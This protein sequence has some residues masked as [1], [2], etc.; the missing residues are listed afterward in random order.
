[1]NAH[2]L[3][4]ILVLVTLLLLQVGCAI[5]PQDSEPR[6]GPAGETVNI[7]EMVSID[8]REVEG[9]LHTVFRFSETMNNPPTSGRVNFP[10]GFFDGFADGGIKSG[11]QLVG[12]LSFNQQTGLPVQLVDNTHATI[13]A[14]PPVNFEVQG[15]SLLLTTSSV[16]PVAPGS[17]ALS[18]LPGVFNLNPGGYNLEMVATWPDAST[19]TFHKLLLVSAALVPHLG[20][21]SFGDSYVG[22]TLILSNPGPSD[23]TVTVRFLRPDGTLLVV[24]IDDL[25]GSIFNLEVP[26]RE[27][28]I[29]DVESADEGTIETG[30]ARL[31]GT[32][33]FQASVFFPT[34]SDS[35]EGGVLRTAAG[36]AAAPPATLHVVPA[37]IVPSYGINTA[38]AIA[39]PTSATANVKLILQ[40]TP[41]VERE[42]QMPSNTQMAAF[43]DSFFDVEVA[44]ELVTSM[45]IYSDTDL[46]AMA[47]VTLNGEQIASLP[48]GTTF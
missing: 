42:I 4:G 24:N 12:T 6:Q 13:N 10:A 29:V 16:S 3:R 38:F 2:T 39:N 21:G 15:N 25:T 45:A 48:S 1:M 35:E 33:P 44:E 41:L 14:F 7:P 47:L 11:F 40:G 31:R 18:F 26:A 36:I 37:A 5:D 30:W 19:F 9:E 43:I 22:S 27:S 28:L 34:F 8:V 32:G 17:Y 46:A 23:I 20:I